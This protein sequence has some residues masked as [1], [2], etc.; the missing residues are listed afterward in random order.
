LNEYA[1]S[2]IKRDFGF[3]G[4]QREWR[5]MIRKIIDAEWMIFLIS[6]ELRVDRM[7]SFFYVVSVT[8]AYI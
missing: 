2:S 7:T 3:D 1:M 4:Q 8:L 5:H 6:Y